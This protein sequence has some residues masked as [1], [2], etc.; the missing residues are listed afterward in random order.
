MSLDMRNSASAA[1][2]WVGVTTGQYSQGRLISK[3]GWKVGF[4]KTMASA[5]YLAKTRMQISC[6]FTAQLICTLVFAY[7]RTILSHATAQIA[8]R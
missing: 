3:Q 8:Q 4:R 2:D 6:A 1:L 5:L 7:L